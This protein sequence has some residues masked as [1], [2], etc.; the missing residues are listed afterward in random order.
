MSFHVH[1]KWDEKSMDFGVMGFSRCAI[2]MIVHITGDY[3]KKT[4]P[5]DNKTTKPQNY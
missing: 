3:Y 1:E 2:S 5:Q 4:K